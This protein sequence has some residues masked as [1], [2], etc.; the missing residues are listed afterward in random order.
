MKNAETPTEQ[1]KFEEIASPQDIAIAKKETELAEVIN[2]T[3]IDLSEAETIKAAYLPFL[4]LYNDIM[5]QAMKI[6][7]INPTML[8]EEIASKLRKAT[9]KI[10]TS[11]E[12]FKTERKSQYLL[13]GNIE[14]SAYNLIANTCK[15]AELE[16]EKVEKA[17]E[18]KEAARKEELK[19]E[20]L[21]QLLP[22]NF[23]NDGTFDLGSMDEKMF[24][25]L[26]RSIVNEFEEKI[27]AD[28]KAE[29]DRIKKEHEEAEAKKKL[30]EENARLKIESDAKDKLLADQKAK[31]EA[32]LA[33]TNRIAKIESDKQAKIIADQKAEA[34]RIADNVAKAA[35]EASEKIK[36]DAKILADKKAAEE[37]AAKEAAKAPDKV[38]MINMIDELKMPL[39]DLKSEESKKVNEDIKAKFASFKKWANDQINSL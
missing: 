1:L 20:R 23:I 31:A 37:K 39:I 16:F 14:Q 25:M 19:K 22:F 27:A 24:K 6:D 4:S 30:E 13:K 15:L 17:T 7:K 34:K 18:I 29:A 10:R 28:V 21:E 33:E 3:G 36:A 35:H 12:A 5:H 9:V 26:H 11:A 2:Q 38:K 32:D 8:D